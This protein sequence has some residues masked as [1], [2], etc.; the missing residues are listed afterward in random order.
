[1]DIKI[2]DELI[3]ELEQCDT[4]YSN[5][6]DLAA[7]YTVKDRL[8]GSPSIANES[9][10]EADDILPA[11]NRYTTSKMLYQLGTG[12]LDAVL[13]DIQLLCSEI[14]ELIESIYNSASIEERRHISGMLT[15]L[16]LTAK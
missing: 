13:S 9:D 16:N 14:S 10:N 2:I 6:R 4:T 1:M 3:N 8:G 5:I 11:Y 12:N 7:L 15:K